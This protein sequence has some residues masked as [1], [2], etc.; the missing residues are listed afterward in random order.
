MICKLTTSCKTVLWAVVLIAL[1]P[2]ADIDVR[3]RT[4]RT[5]AR[6]KERQKPVYSKTSKVEMNISYDFSVPGKT[7][8]IHLIVALPKTM[9]N[10]QRIYDITCS[11]EPVRLFT[12][13]GNDYAEFLFTNPEKQFKVQINIKAR[14]LRYD[15]SIARKKHKKNPPPDPNSHNFLKHEKY[16]E[17]DDPKIQQ[18]AKAIKGNNKATVI[19]NIHDYVIKNMDYRLNK[20]DL[21]ALEAAEKKTG[22]CS[23]YADLF[24][25]ICRAKNIPA[26]VAIGYTTEPALIPRHAWAEVYMRKYG[27]VPFDPTWADVKFKSARQFHYLKSAYIYLTHTR[28]DPVLNGGF[29]ASCRYLGDPPRTKDSIEFK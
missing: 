8:K 14:L 23:E 27:W 28:H 16:I 3:A 24:V 25:A 29:F 7:S 21:G 20:A 11:P 12:E 22:D 19:K 18:I 4:Q 1:V 26:R 2:L 6:K 15:L 5:N 9:P 17:K 10:R 13:N